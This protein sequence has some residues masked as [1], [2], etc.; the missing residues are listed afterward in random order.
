[1]AVKNAGEA[2]EI[3]RDFLIRMSSSTLITPICAE[4]EE[5]KWIVKFRVGFMAMTFEVDAST[6]EILRYCECG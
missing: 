2:S 3:V 6:G 5:N 4:K 1:M